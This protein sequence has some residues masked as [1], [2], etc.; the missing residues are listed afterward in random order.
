LDTSNCNSCHYFQG[1]DNLGQCRRFP[2]Y[3][4]RHKNEWCGEFAEKLSEEKA[5]AEI[6][7]EAKPLGVFSALGMS[8]PRMPAPK[9]GRPRK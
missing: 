6:L 4:N 1:G 8:E 2:V 9:R 3:Q 7:P 5:V